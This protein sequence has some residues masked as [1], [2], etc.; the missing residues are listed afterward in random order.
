MIDGTALHVALGWRLYRMGDRLPHDTTSNGLRLGTQQAL[1]GGLAATRAVK[2]PVLSARPQRIGQAEVAYIDSRSVLSP[3]SGFIKA[4]KFTLNPYS[5]C[6]FACEYCY[7][8][9]FAPSVQDQEA[10]G[11]W[12]R[13]KGHAV[14]L[15][16]KAIRARSDARR[17]M[18]GDA[19]YMSSVT[20]PYQ[21]IEQT[22]G[23]TRA[24]LGELL[25]VQPRL[26]VQTRSPIVMRDIDLLQQFERV[27]VNF[28][29]TTDSE[30]MRLRYE[31]HCPSID[32]R[33]RAAETVAKAG[34]PIGVSISPMLPILDA[35]AFAERLAALSADE[36]VTQFF[37]PT[38]SRFSAGSAPQAL[39]RL[40]EDHWSVQHYRQVRAILARTLGPHIPLREGNDGYRPPEPLYP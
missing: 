20:D 26:T 32:V 40:K 3:A 10:W 27:R 13:V 35:Q 38:R 19:V 31:P 21:P 2:L 18:R 8:R 6:S 4:Y 37:K 39:H 1:S 11:R 30:T 5:G 14:E 33:I 23:L 22:L 17:L 7:A 34:I 29:I 28:T 25:S 12:V 16:R 36:Y 15:L 9:F 24:I